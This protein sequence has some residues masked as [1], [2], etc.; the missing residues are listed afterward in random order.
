M[1]YL[2][3]I[4][5]ALTLLSALAAG[6]LWWKNQGLNRELG[7]LEHENRQLAETLKAKDNARRDRAK[8]DGDIKRLPRADIIDRLQ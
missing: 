6:F 2:R 5:Y 3:L 1:T 8:V 7:R 4:P